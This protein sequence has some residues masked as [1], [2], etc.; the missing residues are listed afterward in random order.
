MD[1]IAPETIVDNS[2]SIASDMFSLGML[3]ISLYN[4]GR[5]LISSQQSMTIYSL[6]KMNVSIIKQKPVELITILQFLDVSEF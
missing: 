3:I 6:Q 2:M 5:S 4:D 1:F